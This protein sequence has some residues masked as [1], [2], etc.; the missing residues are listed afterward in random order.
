MHDFATLEKCAWDIPKDKRIPE[1]G[2][3]YRE[4]AIVRNLSM[5]SGSLNR[6]SSCLSKITD[7]LLYLI[8]ATIRKMSTRII[9]AAL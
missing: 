8:C 9:A 6:L 2:I 1:L 5:I 7:G 3:S 4:H